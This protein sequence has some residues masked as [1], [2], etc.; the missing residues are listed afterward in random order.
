MTGGTG[1]TGGPYI[2]HDGFGFQDA[3]EA[4]QSIDSI[5]A[6]KRGP[7]Q[8]TMGSRSDR[9]QHTSAAQ[10]LHPEWLDRYID[11]TDL[12]SGWTVVARVQVI[13][14]DASCSVLARVR[15]ITDTVNY[16]GTASTST[17]WVSQS[18]VI[19]VPAVLGLKHYQLWLVPGLA[20]INIQAIGEIEIYPS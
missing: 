11:W 15:N 8:L 10:F 20:N 5:A 3:E 14:D 9:W 7:G 13:T 19:P 6:A 18:I 1:G 2:Y 16:D 17:S 4:R 12:E